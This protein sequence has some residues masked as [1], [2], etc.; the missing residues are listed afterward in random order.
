MRKSVLFICGINLLASGLALFIILRPSKSLQRITPI[1]TQPRLQA[2]ALPPESVWPELTR[3]KNLQSAL[4]LSARLPSDPQIVQQCTDYAR[5]CQE[6]KQ[7]D[8]DFGRMAQT[9]ACIQYLGEQLTWDS[10]QRTLLQEIALNKEAPVLLREFA[11]RAV[12]NMAYQGATRTPETVPAGLNEFLRSDFGIETSLE[13][14]VLNAINHLHERG[15]VTLTTSEVADKVL[16]I[17]ENAA[18]AQETTLIAAL[19]LISG[20]GSEVA[21]MLKAIVTHTRSERVAQA[22]V[23]ALHR[24]SGADRSWLSQIPITSSAVYQT[25][26]SQIGSP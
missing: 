11:I 8:L 16:L 2:E 4:K 10:S 21:D 6:I 12:V 9:A 26:E 1:N 18:Q 13:G 7:G 22:A 15:M 19:D 25:V 3:T 20:G 14:V 24:I 23:S 17:V 5:S